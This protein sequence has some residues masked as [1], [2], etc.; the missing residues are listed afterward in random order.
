MRLAGREGVV[1]ASLRLTSPVGPGMA[2]DRILSVFVRRALDGDP[3]LLAGRGTR[4][5]DYVNV[6]DVAAAVASCLRERAAGL[7]NIA[8]GQSTSNLELAEK[9][10][11]LLGSSSEI[12]FTG[13]DDP[14][15]GPNWDVSIAEPRRRFAYRPQ[16][17]LDHSILA[18]ADDNAHRIDR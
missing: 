15:E 1:T 6:R 10:G 4:R 13:V 17:T 12:G 9:C 2:A 7:F 3:L 16:F 11:R 8:A 14:D 5:Q 18:V